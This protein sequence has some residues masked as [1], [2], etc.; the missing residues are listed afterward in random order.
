MHLRIFDCIG[1]GILPLVE[2]QNDLD[3]VFKEVKIPMIKNYSE[4]EEIA[5]YYLSNDKERKEMIK[6]LK[7]FIDKYFSP[8]V[9]VKK[10][11][12]QLF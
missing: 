5:Q 6:E 11:V 2:Y 9:A 3:F 1:S 7:I 8:E 10:I 12:D 4:A